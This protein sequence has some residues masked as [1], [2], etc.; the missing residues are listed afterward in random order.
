MF[1]ASGCGLQDHVLLF[2]PNP[3]L[4]LVYQNKICKMFVA[5]GCGL[6]EH[7]CSLLAA[8]NIQL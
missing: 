2:E 1:V 6:Q 4:V 7:V 8:K 5:S 3:A